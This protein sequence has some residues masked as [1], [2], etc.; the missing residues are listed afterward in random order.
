MLQPRRRL[1]MNSTVQS[2]RAELRRFGLLL[3]ALF[4]AI[5]GGLPLLRHHPAPLW[6]WIVAISLWLSALMAPAALRY[7][8]LGWT[9][10]GAVLGWINTRVILSLLYAVGFIPIAVLMRLSGRDPMAR[11]FEPARESYRVPCRER[12]ASHLERPY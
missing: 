11:K 6:P 9:R 3:G 5:F 2:D 4:A 1:H 7:P 12:P 10:L 8:Y